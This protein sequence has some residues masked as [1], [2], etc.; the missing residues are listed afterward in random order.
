M[1]PRA[2]GRLGLLGLLVLLVLPRS[3][4][5]MSSPRAMLALMT[6]VGPCTVTQQFSL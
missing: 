5:R 1:R 2:R 6:S 4:S 3:L